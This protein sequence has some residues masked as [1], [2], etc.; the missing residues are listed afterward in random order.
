MPPW[1]KDQGLERDASFKKLAEFFNVKLW[2][3]HSF[4]LSN[5]FVTPE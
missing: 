5:W 4:T 1:V 3:E 2:L